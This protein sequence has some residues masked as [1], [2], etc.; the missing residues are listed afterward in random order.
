MVKKTHINF[1][2]TAKLISKVS[3]MVLVSQFLTNFIITFMKVSLI[4]R[5]LN[6]SLESYGH[7]SIEIFF[8]IGYTLKIMKVENSK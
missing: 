3:Q 6:L 8:I 5:N 7:L 1:I 2:I 4:I